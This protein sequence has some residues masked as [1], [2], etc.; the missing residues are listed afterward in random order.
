MPVGAAVGYLLLEL[1]VVGFV[2]KGLNVLFHN[3]ICDAMF[4]CGCTWN[5]AGGW[6]ACNVHNPTGPR[7]PFCASPS[8]RFVRTLPIYAIVSDACVC[9]TVFATECGVA[10]RRLVLRDVD[11]LCVACCHDMDPGSEAKLEVIDNPSV[12]GVFC[13][14]V[15]AAGFRFRV[16]GWHRLPLVPVFH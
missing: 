8:S 15:C 3:P 9:V 2:S 14:A 6:N 4:R 11:V 13:A 7:C 1:T 12:L 16:L 10:D 5:W